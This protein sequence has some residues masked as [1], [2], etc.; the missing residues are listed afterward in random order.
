MIRR[1]APLVALCI[2]TAAAAQPD[3]GP[4]IEKIDFKDPGKL[5]YRFTKGQTES[6]LTETKTDTKTAVS[7]AGQEMNISAKGTVRQ[8]QTMKALD[9]AVPAKVEVVTEHIQMKQSVDG[10][11]FAVDITVDDKKVKATSGG[12]VLVDSEGPVDNRMLEQFMQGIE[13]FGKKAVILINP[14]GRFTDKIEGDAVAVKFLRDQPEKSLFPVV[15]KPGDGFKVGDT[16]EVES[17]TRSMQQMELLKPIKIKTVYKIVGSATVD[18]VPCTEIESTSSLKATDLEAT[19]K[20]MGQ[21]MKM[22]IAAV[23]WTMK[24]RAFYDPAK[25]R[26]VFGTV[27]G[28]V[29]VEA[30]MDVQGAGQTDVKVAVDLDSTIRHNAPWK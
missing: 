25:N 21:D 30:S 11:M 3:K 24:G 26:P 27:K 12:Q 9:D 4:K 8:L 1:I 18:G 19:I 29:E 10:G 23:A 2:A 6:Y 13:H 7:V 16:W 17:E 28:T 20:Q 22:K 15:W 5:E 14:D